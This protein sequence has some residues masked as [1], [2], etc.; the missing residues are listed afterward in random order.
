M[1][2]NEL[3]RNE[4]DCLKS[5]IVSNSTTVFNLGTIPYFV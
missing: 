4:I 5:S 2:R 3:I 1:K